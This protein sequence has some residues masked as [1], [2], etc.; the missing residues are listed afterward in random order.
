VVPGAPETRYARTPDGDHVAY[1]ILGNG[2]VDLL[3]VGY[4]NV[5]SIDQRDDEPHVRRF[6][7]RLAAFSR[8]I[9]FDR[10][11]IGLSDRPSSGDVSAAT[12][13]DDIVAVLDAAGSA[14]ASIFG[15]GLSG[16]PALLA[17]ARHPDRVGSL[18]LV[19]TYARQLWAE[20]Y[21]F[22]TPQSIL[23]RFLDG[24]LDVAKPVDEPEVDDVRLMAP[25]LQHDRVFRDWW[26]RAGRLGA[27]PAMARLILK[28]SF[29]EDVRGELAAIAAPTLIL[30][31]DPSLFPVEHARYLA[32]HIR[33]AHLVV[34]PGGD[35]LPFGEGSDAIVDE[36]EEFLT[37]SRGGAATERILTTVLFTDI[38]GSTEQA[39]RAGDRSWHE[40]LDSHD[41]LVRSELRRFGG[42]EVKTTGDGIL[43]TFASPTQAIRCAT[44]IC[45]GATGMGLEVRAGLHTGEVEVRG[46]DVSGIAVHLAQ[47]ISGRSGA[48]EVL[49]SRTVVD[50]VAGSDT[51]FDDRGTHELKGFDGSWPLFSVR[52]GL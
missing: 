7:H 41:A 50:L 48:G 14:R 37:G 17:A 34:L 18:V 13:A 47:R 11:G 35:D 27:S 10:R 43:A 16:P 6:E 23:D 49:V 20:D 19:H 28:T 8:F 21:P 4:G 26:A 3:C 30:H 38:V 2:S 9:R 40:V 33:D 39:T 31:R 29:E 22:G 52:R 24:V 12:V 25:S 44:A 51:A 45:G 1:Q 5:V 32:A 46:D 36:V 15:T 42:R